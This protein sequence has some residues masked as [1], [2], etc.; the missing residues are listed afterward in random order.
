[1]KEEGRRRRRIFVS[2]VD[3]YE[4]GREKEE[5]GRKIRMKRCSQRCN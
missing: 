1:M 4:G 3:C 2:L 5:R